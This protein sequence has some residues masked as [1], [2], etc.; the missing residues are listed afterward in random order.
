LS[1]KFAEETKENRQ[2]EQVSLTLDP[3]SIC[4]V[5]LP[6]SSEA[7]PLTAALLRREVGE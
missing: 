7:P 3:D 4:A 2:A 1:Q 5:F 6:Q